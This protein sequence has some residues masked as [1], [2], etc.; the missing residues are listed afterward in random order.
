VLFPIK[1]ANDGDFP[2]K[3]RKRSA[4]NILTAIALNYVVPANAGFSAI[5]DTPA[6]PEHSRR[7]VIRD[8]IH[9]PRFTVYALR[10]LAKT[11]PPRPS[12]KIVPGSG[13]S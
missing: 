9:E 2:P 13:I 11:R 6:C 12:S 1:S 4:S 8:T 7:N 5:G 10:F 3:P